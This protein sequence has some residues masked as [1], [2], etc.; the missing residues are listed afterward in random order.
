MKFNYIAVHK[1]SFISH[2]AIET[3]GATRLDGFTLEYS[4]FMGVTRGSGD[5][6]SLNIELKPWAQTK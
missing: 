1:I 3:S 5:G 2:V 4:T 6:S